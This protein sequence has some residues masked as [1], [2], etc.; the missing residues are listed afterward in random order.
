MYHSIF[1]DDDFNDETYYT[2]IIQMLLK[3]WKWFG[4]VAVETVPSSVLKRSFTFS[5]NSQQKRRKCFKLIYTK[6]NSLIWI[7][8]FITKIFS[9]G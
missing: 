1:N 8:I 2:I 7:C 6:V 9:E 4:N 5:A 3:W